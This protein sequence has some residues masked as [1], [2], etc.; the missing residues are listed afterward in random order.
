MPIEFA[1]EL[2]DGIED[3]MHA[4][5]AKQGTL[6]CFELESLIFVTEGVSNISGF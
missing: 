1:N 5:R 3:E 6:G 2:E 4:P